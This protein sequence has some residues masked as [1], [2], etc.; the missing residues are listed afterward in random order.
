MIPIRC[1]WKVHHRTFLG[2]GCRAVSAVSKLRPELTVGRWMLSFPLGLRLVV[3][4]FMVPRI[5]WPRLL[6]SLLCSRCSLESDESW[7]ICNLWNIGE[8]LTELLSFHFLPGGRK[9]RLSEAYTHCHVAH[10]NVS[11]LLSE[12]RFSLISVETNMQY[13]CKE[14]HRI[15]AEVP[16]SSAFPLSH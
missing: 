10:P 4:L 3:P 15:F 2:R 6:L 7:G 8:P 14:S 11:P 13:V 16:E 5:R 1:W 12:G 9:Y